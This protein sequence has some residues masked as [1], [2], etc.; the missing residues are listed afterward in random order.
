MEDS[1]LDLIQSHNNATPMHL[2]Q[3]SQIMSKSGFDNKF[4]VILAD[5]TTEHAFVGTQSEQEFL[6]FRQQTFKPNELKQAYCD[7]LEE[8]KQ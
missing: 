3:D 7:D 5:A 1:A 2:T 4:S 6:S 8:S